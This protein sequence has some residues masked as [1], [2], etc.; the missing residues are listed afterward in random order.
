MAKLPDIQL[1]GRMGNVIFYVRNGKQCMRALPKK[2]KNPNSKAQSK[3]RKQFSKASKFTSAVL[4]DLIHPYWNVKA[5]K[6]KRSGY[7]LFISTNIMA[8]ENDSINVNK[9][10]LVPENGLSQE[11]FTFKKSDNNCH[12]SWNF[13]PV[14]PKAKANDSL[15][16]FLLSDKQELTILKNIAKRSHQQATIKIPDNYNAFLLWEKNDKWSESLLVTD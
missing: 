10:I 9:L 4:R 7:N 15:S 13:K 1:S 12:V 5:K 16:L 14:G 6:D 2:V 3:Y 8:F 11:K